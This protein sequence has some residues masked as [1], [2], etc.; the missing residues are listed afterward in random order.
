MSVLDMA[1]TFEPPTADMPLR[2]RYTSYLGEQHPAE[3]KVVLEFSPADMP[4]LTDVQR[5]KLKKLA[6]VRYNPDKDII[7]ISCDSFETQS[8][9]KRYLGDLVD[10]LLHES[11]VCFCSSYP[12][13]WNFKNFTD[14]IRRPEILSRMYHL[15]YD[16][17]ASSQ[18][19]SSPWSGH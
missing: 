11:R 6:G 7:K 8:Q 1:K 15:I 19:L 2:F 16:T 10:S 9:N 12:I 13:Y 3:K 17:T 4:N 18:S 5:E 14:T